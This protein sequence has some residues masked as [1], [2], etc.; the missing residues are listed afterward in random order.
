MS[1]TASSE[2]FD[3]FLSYASPN[4]AWES[5]RSQWHSRGV[6]PNGWNKPRWW[7]GVPATAVH[8]TRPRARSLASTS[9]MTLRSVVPPTSDRYAEQALLIGLE[10]E[11]PQIIRVA[12]VV[13]AK[14]RK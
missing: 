2:Q 9:L 13:L 11:D 1:A 6:R 10:I 4:R 8:C 5:R 12:S 3:V 7:S 14:L